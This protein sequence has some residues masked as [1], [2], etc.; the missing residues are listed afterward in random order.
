MAQQQEKYGRVRKGESQR[1][2]DGR[3]VY[4]YT[5]LSRKT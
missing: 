2:S 1:R 3:Y 5:D 4:T